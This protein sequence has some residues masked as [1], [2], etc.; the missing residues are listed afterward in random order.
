MLKFFR[1]IRYK[2]L[3]VGDLKKY[4]KY[5][6]GEILLVVIGIL[7]ALQINNWNE[8]KKEAAFEQKML[9]EIKTSL[10]QD[11]AHTSQL[12]NENLVNREQAIK[13]LLEV[14]AFNKTEYDTL[15]LR[16]DLTDARRTLSFT[17][18]RGPYESLKALGL[19]KISNDSL[20]GFLVR[21]Y[22][23]NLPLV[24]NFFENQEDEQETKRNTYF[25]SIV[26]YR[27]IKV[28]EKDTSLFIAKV[29]DL[30]TLQTNHDFMRLMDLEERMARIYRTGLEKAKAD[31]ERM[32]MYVNAELKEMN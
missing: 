23:V 16:N 17:Y 24:A 1:R 9:V 18:D 12:I 5:A 20:R 11:L 30:K 6:L 31:L 10:T 19:D 8:D 26:E 7:V 14:V 15:A 28:I 13:R 4:L 2:L 3:D 27:M 22:E 21:L 29:T 25:D 32:V